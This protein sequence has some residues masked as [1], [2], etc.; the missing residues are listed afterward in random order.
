MK[1]C[2]V[3]IIFINKF[4]KNMMV[5]VLETV[6]IL[7]NKLLKQENYGNVHPNIKVVQEPIS[8]SIILTFTRVIWHTD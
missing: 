7:L 1:I 4:D 6:L 3:P 8:L 2:T 5:T